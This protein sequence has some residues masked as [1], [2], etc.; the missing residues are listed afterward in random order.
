[1]LTTC[2]KPQE[3][4]LS[5]Q[6]R[7]AAETPQDHRVGVEILMIVTIED[8]VSGV[9]ARGLRDSGRLLSFIGGGLVTALPA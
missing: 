2:K 8:M 3:Y 7:F 4:L 9:Y 1:M 6:N 5:A